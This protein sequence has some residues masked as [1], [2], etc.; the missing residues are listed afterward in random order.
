MNIDTL[1]F[2]DRFVGVVLCWVFTAFHFSILPFT[3]HRSLSKPRRVLI[4]KLSEMGSTV[5]AYPAIQELQQRVPGLELFFITFDSN[6]DILDELKWTQASNIFTVNTDSL[7]QLL[8]TGFRT[9]SRLRK[10]SVDTSIDM[11]FFSRFSAILSYLV[12]RGNRVGFHR[13]TNE[14][15]GR[16]RLLTH[17]VIY[18]PHV[19]TSMAFISLV[20]ALFER[21]NDDV[22]YKGPISN[23]CLKAPLY[24]PDRE[25]VENVEL[26][27]KRHGVDLSENGIV[28]VLVNPNSSDILP[29]R[30]W[31]LP[32]FKRFCE[33]L[34]EKKTNVYIVFTGAE[35]E[36]YDAEKIMERVNNRRCVSLVGL[37]SFQE[38][39]ALYSLADLIITN[40]SGPA[41]FASLLRLPTIVLFGPETPRLYSPLGGNSKCLYAEFACSPC[42]SVYNSKK[43]PCEDNRCMKAISV[44]RVLN[45]GLKVLD[46]EK[47]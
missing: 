18:S 7:W 16:G 33:L 31:P 36:R 32:N 44:E 17:R 38:L 21:Q 22:K 27:L 13:F 24:I 43:S 29:L 2:I 5:L 20:R 11:D 9:I 34:L 45:E 25:A 40:D 8:F 1:R 3:L 12:C 30:K 37:T 10:E 19:H 47:N 15:L 35:S 39:L 41:H 23:A 28:L 42:I 46:G 6:R 26:K 4:I 14:G